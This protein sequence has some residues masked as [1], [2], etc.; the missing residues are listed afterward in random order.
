MPRVIAL[1]QFQQFTAIN[2]LV[3]PGAIGGPKIVPSCAEIDILFGLPGGKIAHCI[4][5]GR[6]T[7]AFAGT[8]AQANSILTA[9]TAGIPANGF[10]LHLSGQTTI[11]GVSIRDVNT[12]NQAVISSNVGGA[13]GTGTGNA[14]PNEVAICVTKH[15]AL[16][17]RANRGRF[18]V[19]G[20][21]VSTVAAD[22]TVIPTAVTDLQ[23]WANTLQGA[24]NA[25]GYQMVIGQPARQAYIGTSGTSHPARPAG[26]VPVTSL[27]VRD[28]HFDSQRRRGLK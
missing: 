7:G 25:S 8:V 3:D 24:F 27:F 10:L 4:F 28:N 2:L 16:A 18:Y 5:H 11:G 14:V 17:G 26:S 15:T 9:I 21:I 12:A 19:P 22:N 1:D 6:Y 13:T 20:W 23:T